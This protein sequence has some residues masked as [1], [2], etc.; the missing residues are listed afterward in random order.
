[1]YICV[2]IHINGTYEIHSM[3]ISYKCFPWAFLASM[4]FANT[5]HGQSLPSAL[6]FLNLSCFGM[7]CKSGSQRCSMDLYS[8][9]FKC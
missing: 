4:A 5:K 9:W 1:M 8:S 2:C 6:P 3:L 7:T